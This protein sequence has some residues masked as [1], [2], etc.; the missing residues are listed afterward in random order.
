MHNLSRSRVE[1]ATRHVFLVMAI[2]M[3]WGTCWAGLCSVTIAAT[4][5]EEEKATSPRAY[6]RRNMWLL[7]NY[8]HETARLLTRNE[9]V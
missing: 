3:M 5:Y 9:T 7:S 8:V 6:Y 4:C 2:E 1:S